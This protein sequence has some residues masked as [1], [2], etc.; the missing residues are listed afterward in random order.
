[1]KWSQ[2]VTIFIFGF[3][4]KKLQFPS[5]RLHL[6]CRAMFLVGVCLDLFA[7]LV[8]SV[9]LFI[10]YKV[11]VTKPSTVLK[12]K[13]SFLSLLAEHEQLQIKDIL[14]C[15][16]RNSQIISIMVN[17]N[18]FLFSFSYSLAHFSV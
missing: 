11:Q 1:M 15:V 17:K 4:P 12:L 13:T 18:Y 10:S 8:G 9:V 5:S 16:V 3:W 2:N 14:V 6:A 7:Y